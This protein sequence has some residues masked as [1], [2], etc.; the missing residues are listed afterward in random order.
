VSQISWERVKL[1][2]QDMYVAIAV[3]GPVFK[4]IRRTS[5]NRMQGFLS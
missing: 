3:G 5:L 4:N 1:P 2:L